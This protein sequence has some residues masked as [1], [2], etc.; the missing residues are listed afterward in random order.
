MPTALDNLL[1]QIDPERTVED[2][3]S[4]A[5]EAINSFDIDVAQIDEWDQFWACMV[6]LY[7]HVEHHTLRLKAPL[8]LEPNFYWGLCVRVLLKLYGMNGEKAAFEMARTGNEGG[9]Y[10]VI[11]AV[12]MKMAETYSNTRQS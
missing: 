2:T 7:R 9:L 5:N 3:F 6:R 8:D 12:A 10:A 4:R 1:M 11:K